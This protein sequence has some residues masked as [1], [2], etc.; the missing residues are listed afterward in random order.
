MEKIKN[1][2]KPKNLLKWPAFLVS[3][4]AFVAFLITAIVTCTRTFSYGTYSFEE[5][6]NGETYRIELELDDEMEA[7]IKETSITESDINYSEREIKFRVVGNKLYCTENKTSTKLEYT[8]D[9]SAFELNLGVVKLKNKGAEA[10]YI[11][12]IVFSGVFVS[13]ALINL[14]YIL[15]S[16]KKKDV[17]ANIKT[18]DA[19]ETKETVSE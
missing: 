1:F 5:T 6:K 19:L 2:F 12:S 15:T 10:L 8:G 16:K 17:K 3:T 13:C 18:E 9:I 7:E 14:A 4:L 11:C